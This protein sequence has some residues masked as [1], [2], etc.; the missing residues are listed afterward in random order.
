MS[1]RSPLLALGLLVLLAGCTS[2]AEPARPAAHLTIEVVEDGS[3]TVPGPSPVASAPPTPAPVVLPSP[4]G[5]PLPRDFFLALEP[6]YRAGTVWRRRISSEGD[7]LIDITEV[8]AVNGA[9]AHLRQHETRENGVTAVPAREFDV[10]AVGN[11]LT[12]ALPAALDPTNPAMEVRSQGT[13]D[14]TVPAGTYRGCAKVAFSGAEGDTI[15]T[16]TAWL[17]PG[18][19]LVKLEAVSGGVTNLQELLSITAP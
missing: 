1:A 3:T 8:L 6:P 2:P 13:E 7:V 17:A 9:T 14:V 12:A 5:E 10:P 18:V 4:P 15:Y 11:P 16:G 19:G